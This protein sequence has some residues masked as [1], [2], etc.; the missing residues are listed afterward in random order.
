MLQDEAVSCYC[1][2]S[3]YSTDEHDS[4]RDVSVLHHSDSG[5]DLSESSRDLDW[6]RFWTL[7]GERLI[8]E[9]WILKYGSYIDPVYLSNSSTVDVTVTAN[10]HPADGEETSFCVESDQFPNPNLKTSFSGLLENTRLESENCKSSIHEGKPEENSN[11]QIFIDNV[12]SESDYRRLSDYSDTCKS[13]SGKSEDSLNLDENGFRL[14]VSSRCSGSSAMLS[15]T[16]DSMTNITRMTLSSSDSSCGID[17]SSVKSS[18]A[19]SSSDSAN[20]ADQQWQ[21]LWAEHFNEQYYYHY[22]KF[23]DRLAKK[24]DGEEVRSDS[25]FIIEE[26]KTLSLTQ[27]QESVDEVGSIETQESVSQ[28]SDHSVADGSKP[29]SKTILSHKQRLVHMPNVCFRYC[30]KLLLVNEA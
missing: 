10:Q 15:A 17:D 6:E 26:S 1:S 21:H 3:H 16:T 25:G 24:R 2:A 9:S 29:S 28:E 13:V 14:G 20:S 7:N 23:T 4:L 18:S 30:L 11:P 19:L 27:R 12:K 22:N 8:W 5:A